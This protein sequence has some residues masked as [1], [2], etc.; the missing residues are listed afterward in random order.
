MN[1]KSVR[2]KKLLDCLIWEYYICRTPLASGTI[3][4]KYFP[5]MSPATIRSDLVHLED[6]GYIYQPHTSAGR[7][8]T[9]AGYREYVRQNE[10]S[11]LSFEKVDTLKRIVCENFRDAT[12]MLDYILQI[13]ASSVGQLCFVAEPEISY[14]YLRNLSVFKISPV[15]LLFVVSLSSGLDK[16]IFVKCDYQI[17]TQQLNALTR[18][19]N[20]KFSGLR[21]YDIQTK[22][23]LDSANNQENSLLNLFLRELYNALSKMGGYFLNFDGNISFLEQP[24]FDSKN[25]ILNF[26]GMMR[27]QEILVKLMQEN[28]PNDKAG[29]ILGDSLPDSSWREFVLIYA[30]YDLFGIPGY[31]GTLSPLRTDYAKNISSLVG[32]ART[33]T[34][35][36]RDM[37]IVRY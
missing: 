35:T 2:R 13:L 23:L 18:Y 14:E 20:Q 5:D 34:A 29:I 25:N 7:I 3:C 15:K 17:T 19:V 30:K 26:F 16:T 37:G 12:T 10:F 36:T 21:I 8:P 28:D 27:R 11:D 22:Y 9:I 33:I 6:K 1:K 32:I 24:E 4:S 31:L